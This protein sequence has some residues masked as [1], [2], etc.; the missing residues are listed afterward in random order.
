ME[1]RPEFAHSALVVFV[2]PRNRPLCL[3]GKA[4]SRTRIRT[5]QDVYFELQSWQQHRNSYHHKDQLAAYVSVQKG[6]ACS[7]E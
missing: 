7:R 3:F 4:R 1:Y 2:Q 5:E 6:E